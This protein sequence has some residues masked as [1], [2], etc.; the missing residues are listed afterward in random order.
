MTNFPTTRGKSAWELLT[1]TWL[2]LPVAGADKALDRIRD[3][4]ARSF[5]YL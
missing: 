1:S 5:Y 2:A 3:F 4:V